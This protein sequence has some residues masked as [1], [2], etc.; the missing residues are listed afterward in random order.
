[1]KKVIL[2]IAMLL[3]GLTGLL[4]Q[5]TR[6]SG[7]FNPTNP[8]D[9]G[10][11]TIT[12]KY[13]LTTQVSPSTAGSTSPTSTT[14]AEGATVNVYAYKNSNYVFKRWL[15]GDS[16][17]STSA[18][19]SY[20]MPACDVQLTAVFEFDPSDPAD[21]DTASTAK[22]YSATV[23][24]S[25]SSGGSFN[26]SSPSGKEGTTTTIYAYNNTNYKFSGWQIDGE[27]VSTSTPYTLTFD[28][29]DIVLTG[30]FTFNPSNPSN[31]GAN[32]FDS[33]TGQVIIDDF[34]S[35]SLMS[36][37][38][39]VIG[40]SSYRSSVQMVTVIGSMSSSDFGFVDYLSNCTYIDLS[41]AYG[42]TSIPTYAFDGTNL[43]TVLLP[44][45]V[46][47][48]GNRAFRNC[49][50]LA[51]LS[52]YSLTPPS[53]G[54][55]V[56]DGVPDGLVVYVPA[57]SIEIYAENEDWG[58]FTLL[59]LE[60]EAFELEVSLP[61]DASDGRYKDMTLEL[62]NA[63]SGQK[64]KYVITDR[65]TYT[66]SSLLS[67][68]S[69]NLYVK[70]SA[71]S[72][73]GTISDVS[74]ADEDVQVAFESLLQPQDVS[75]AILAPDGTD[76]TSQTTITW[77]DA[78][79]SYLKQG[80]QLTSQIEGTELTFRV[81]LPQTLAMLY[82]APNDS[83]Y[84]VE[85]GDNSISL[86]LEAFPTAI[87][88]G[89]VKD[90][91]TNQAI[92]G[93]V[94]SI[95]QVLGRQYTKTY[96]AKTN[97]KGFF[98]QEVLG[99]VSTL[100]ASSSDYVSLSLDSLAISDSTDVGNILLESIK[101]VTITTNF[102]Y[103][104]SVAAGEESTATSYYSDYANV[105][106]TI[107]DV[108]QSKA[109]TEFS[110]QYPQIA[111]LE[112][113]EEGD[114]LR[115]TASSKK[116]AFTDVACEAT[117]ADG[118]A[119]AT[120]DIV[121]LGGISASF[122]STDNA[123]VV[124]ILYDSNGQLIKK[125]TYSEAS[126]AI[127]DL[128]DGNYSLVS[129]GSST[130]FNSI[131][132]I[133]QL[134][135][136]GLT[137]GTD[138]LRNDLEVKSGL[139]TEVSNDVVPVLDESLLYYTG[140][141]TTFTVN[142]TSIVSGNY[143]TLK[144]KIDFKGDYS[145][146][147][148]D[149]SLVVDLPES[150]SFVEN[151]VMVG[152][153]LSGYTIDGS[154]ITIPVSNLSDQVRFCVIPTLG[155]SY[156]PN[157]FASF[158]LAGSDV[159]QPIGS[160]PFE[161]S[162]LSITVPSI[163]AKTSL[164][165]SGTA[166][167]KSSVIIYEDNVIIG[168]TT[169]LANGTWNA[170]CQLDAPYNL[171]THS[172]YAKVI[173]PQGLQLQTE[174]S[175][176]FYDRDA[177]EVSKVTM[178]HDNP[179]MN[180]TYE[181]VFDFL[182][183]SPES[184]TYTYYIYNREFTFTIEFTDND[185][186]KVS[187][188][189]LYV[190]TGLGNIQTLDAYFDAHLGYWAASGQ[191]GNMYNGDIPVNV[192]VDFV[193]YSDCV[194]D[195]LQLRDSQCLLADALEEMNYLEVDSLITVCEELLSSESADYST[196][197]DSI[198]SI[199][200]LM[201]LEEVELN[202]TDKA[203]VDS[204][205]AAETEEQVQSILTSIIVTYPGPDEDDTDGWDY[206]RGNLENDVVV[207][208]IPTD[209]SNEII[210]TYHKNTDYDDTGSSASGY[211]AYISEGE[212]IPDTTPYETTGSL[213]SEAANKI[214]LT[215]TANGDVL[216]I[217][218][219][220]NY[221][222][223]EADTDNSLY[224]SCEVSAKIVTDLQS[225]YTPT[226][227]D[228]LAAYQETIDNL[229]HRIA[230]LE[231]TRLVMEDLA[232]NSAIELTGEVLSEF[233]QFLNDACLLNETSG[234]YQ[235][236]KTAG[237]A[238]NLGLTIAGLYQN[239]TSSLES[240]NDWYDL[241]G[242]LY[243]H[244]EHDEA[245]RLEKLAS[246]YLDLHRHKNW[247]INLCNVG[248]AALTMVGLAL[249]PETAGATLATLSLAGIGLG[250]VTNWFDRRF[251]NDN[252]RY[253]NDLLDEINNSSKCKPLDDD[254][255]GP[256]KSGNP[257]ATPKIDP[258][259]YVYEG[260]S[261]N[262]L[263]GVTATCYYKETLEDMY[264]DQYEVVDVWDASAYA[265]E[266]PLFTD[267]NG[268]YRWD[269]PEGLWQV[270]F[271]KEG[272]VTTYSD[273]LPVP[274]PQL[275]VNIAMTQNAQPEVSSARAYE[276]GIEVEFDKYMLPETMT[277]DYVY[278]QV[279]DTLVAGSVSLLNEEV[280]YEGESDTYVSRIR[281]VPETAFLSGDEVQLTVS[282]KVKSY[283]GIQMQSDF[284]QAFDIE[285]E[286]KSLSVDSTL[287]VV[288][289]GEKT[290]VIS[291]L[292]YDA[293]VGK[294]LIAKTSSSMIAT[295]SADT[296][297]LDANGQ[298]TI[299][300]N[301]L[302]PGSTMATFTLADAGVSGQ[303][304]VKVAT[305]S[306][307]T[308]QPV[309]SRASGTAV[310]RGTEVELTSET[311]GAV[312]YYTTDGTC[313][314]DENGTRQVYEGPIAITE[315]MTIRAMAVADDMIESDV[316]TFSYSIRTA[317]LGLNLSEGWNWI[318]HNMESAVAISELGSNVSA[319]KGSS[320]EALLDDATGLLSGTL[321][322][323][324]APEAYKV[325][326]TAASQIVLSGYEYNG[327]TPISLMEGCNYIGYPLDQTMTP[328]E[329]FATSAIDDGDCLVGQGGFAIYSDSLWVGTL[330]TMNP[331]EGFLFHSQTAKQVAYNMS[332]V[333]NA[334]SLYAGRRSSATASDWVAD[335]RAY[336]D[337]M[338]LVA[339]LYDEGTKAGEDDYAVYAFSGSECRGVGSWKD[340]LLLMSI[341]G[342]ADEKISFVA[343]DSDGETYAISE[344]LTF[345]ETLVGSLAS[346]QTLTIDAE[347]VGIQTAQ[348]SLLKIWP[349]VV[350]DLLYVSAPSQEADRLT[351]FSLAGETV[352]TFHRPVSGSGIDV[353][354]LA[355]GI[356]IARL[357]SQGQ[358]LYRKIIKE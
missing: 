230:I 173:T 50:Q 190:E 311:E 23:V 106:Y 2:A 156:S 128:A 131:L 122:T 356:Y 123:S 229:N 171:S 351:I 358:C 317:T 30:L 277:T 132:N 231:E 29:D 40:G 290:L 201:D 258:S 111:L 124:G 120:F 34:T 283:A 286:V 138:Y 133:S 66:F 151:S 182:N 65:I 314:C 350:G 13:T 313:P 321:S 318:S 102:T 136:A 323:L 249:A 165:V 121:E 91:S 256:Y 226:L 320:S 43:A 164:A 81:S 49:E 69:Y 141:N 168:E 105:S 149:V 55:Y 292:P 31:P 188:V 238:L 349:L 234:M 37:I 22:T 19:F 163:V 219:N 228:Q 227:S 170:T 60:D 357:E 8:G 26:Q 271:E 272:Y 169:S 12:T 135:S 161:V 146:S 305:S 28:R 270:K 54:T 341:Y 183:P 76:L 307:F 193:S 242:D 178:Y 208:S 322:A 57:S 167:G 33:S 160:A 113:V 110:V 269:V 32:Y 157:A 267:E 202:E 217:D 118:T 209:S 252:K 268:M 71:G 7:D 35:G 45:V 304:I 114:V 186:T 316:A 87:V 352:L 192:S 218:F 279:A 94:V 1:M 184:Q 207:I 67:N 56:F 266:N 153:S 315:D 127:D 52:L 334:K 224:Y 312:I 325:K 47:T 195:T 137:E 343:L 301:G 63:A 255:P 162:D 152:S 330:E 243:T 70:N 86:T 346:P 112:D 337:I 9:P 236:L 62:V 115:L 257:N 80:A 116:S 245:E 125:Y 172:I 16:V 159:L 68:T 287:N 148:D 210:C 6:S 5:T 140:D 244:C 212:W 48:I 104:E 166:T 58:S 276:E 291:A 259:G 278:V 41:R 185:T 24:A 79:G 93:A 264:G 302:L 83:T 348:A 181:V 198:Q 329:A 155:G 103:T 199:I 345:S 253:Y 221:L 95:S 139:I 42:F 75:L 99:V 39:N 107:Y 310:Y 239:Q 284:S 308:L 211:D 235:A 143:L 61:D 158:T 326:A 294:T 344:T 288:Y 342:A 280:S 36:A 150:C 117:V 263:E 237:G 59:P 336:S 274:P 177:V 197:S 327:A 14:A 98:S 154:R 225:Y 303:T 92:S 130:Y 129:M 109:I 240:Q 246:K 216:E 248:S 134:S 194:L 89:T 206:G 296:L 285:K 142:K 273:W 72:I 306:M 215:N 220:N 97:S 189:R 27:I 145:S 332:I 46:E 38:D 144:A 289:G 100:T 232:K 74:I 11:P 108:T 176:C 355:Q 196:I 147:V 204:L 96:T 340:G 21:P 328:T 299:T 191:F 88:S 331:G 84:I 18:S 90:A 339:N 260:V 223:S 281:F 15:E 309:A 254:G 353:S 300:I 25:P 64:Q 73:L 101:G 335:K 275:E 53:L 3:V 247:G 324:N 180:T 298:A 295:L 187:N 200:D 82:E 77:L 174:T 17:V 205:L 214:T 354:A 282:R 265:Q 10:E 179:E 175:D 126:L 262:R 78:S 261:S 51:S 119:E 241:I 213:D 44:S 297:T 319:I 85:D 338:C 4:A 250:M 347:T 293:A 251:E 233:G 203:F 333:S 222:S 20:V